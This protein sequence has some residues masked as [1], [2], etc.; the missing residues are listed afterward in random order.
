MYTSLIYWYITLY[1]KYSKLIL[2]H[3]W[4]SWL[5]F[6][7]IFNTMLV[8]EIGDGFCWWQLWYFGDYFLV[9]IL[10]WLFS[11][12]IDCLLVFIQ[13]K[14]WKSISLVEKGGSKTFLDVPKIVHFDENPIFRSD[15]ISRFRLI[16]I[17][18][19]DM[20]KSMIIFSD[21]ERWIFEHIHR[22][23]QSDDMPS[24]PVTFNDRKWLRKLNCRLLF[25]R[26]IVFMPDDYFAKTT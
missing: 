24:L 9:T 12:P 19:L 11:S 10:W 8:A 4:S 18:I 16:S 23:F 22:I 25:L 14:F 5:V 20:V 2:Y 17:W 3:I 7:T 15:P 26:S 13:M 21:H 6:A 1:I